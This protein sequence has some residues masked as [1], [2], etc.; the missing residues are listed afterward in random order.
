MLASLSELD[1][2]LP[3]NIVQKRDPQLHSDT[4]NTEIK[5]GTISSVH[6]SESIYTCIFW[7]LLLADSLVH[8]MICASHIPSK[9]IFSKELVQA[10]FSDNEII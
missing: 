6:M 3:I 8:K 4:S 7:L 1:C 9:D 5:V 10:L 2:G